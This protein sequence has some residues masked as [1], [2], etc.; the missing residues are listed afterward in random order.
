MPTF[1]RRPLRRLLNGAAPTDRRAASA[2]LLGS[3][4]EACEPR[5]LL[6]GAEPRLAV[7]P[8]DAINETSP[9]YANT[10]INDTIDAGGDVDL[11]RVSV[12]AGQQVEFDIDGFDTTGFDSEIRLFD[13]AG[14]QLAF[15][16]DNLAPGESGTPVRDAYIAQTFAEA[17]DYYLGVTSHLNNDYDILTGEDDNANANSGDYT[18]VITFE[19]GVGNDPND[20]ASEVRSQTRVNDF[21]FNGSIDYLGDVSLIPIGVTA[22]QTV[23]FDVNDAWDNDQLDTELRLFDAAGNVVAVQDDESSATR[24]PY[25][26]HTF[27]QTGL[28]Y[29]GIAGYRNDNYNPFTGRGDGTADPSIGTDT[30]RFTLAVDFRDGDGNADPD[31]QAIEAVVTSGSRSFRGTLEYNN[32]VD[33]YGFR[34]D[35]GRTVRFDTDLEG[36]FGQFLD[37]EIRLF[38][39]A[40]NELA[41]ND[42][43]NAPGE[44]N[45]LDSYLEYTFATA[46]TYYLAVADYRHDSYDVLTGVDT[47]ATGRSYGRYTLHAN[48]DGSTPIHSIQGTTATFST[49]AG[50]SGWRTLTGQIRF[51]DLTAFPEPDAALDGDFDGDGQLDVVLYRQSANRWSLMSNG[52]PLAQDLGPVP[53]TLRDV[54]AGDYNGDGFTDLAGISTAGDA[55]WVGLSVGSALIWSNWQSLPTTTGWQNV[56]VGDFNGDGRDDLAMQ[57]TSNG[58]W[59]FA[60][61]ATSGDR[62]ATASWGDSFGTTIQFAGIEVADVDGDGKDELIAL[63]PVTGFWLVGFVNE[64]ATFETWARWT[65]EARWTNVLVGDFD[66]DGRDDVAAQTATPTGDRDGVWYVAPSVLNENAAPEAVRGRFVGQKWSNRWNPAWGINTFRAADINGDGRTDLIGQADNGGWLVGVSTGESLAQGSGFDFASAAGLQP[67]PGT[68]FVL[69]GHQPTQPVDLANPTPPAPAPNAAAAFAMSED[70]APAAVVLDEAIGT[71]TLDELFAAV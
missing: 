9:I 59:Y 4:V 22:G 11:F 18:L 37:T 47:N 39:D 20:Q 7:D 35:A 45:T 62:F 56:R 53:T 38:D 64:E 29:I 34:V 12:H 44:P 8:N 70:D 60:T 57:T 67:L 19:G 43:G 49:L 13:A 51:P 40:G 21:T 71:A 25:L 69:L 10:Q 46:G 55:I 42:D 52:G 5:V 33:V 63:N 6:A 48:Y 14:T 58:K 36:D 50:P 15:S 3:V 1:S 54:R 23:I 16:D 30:G 31:D 2:L 32:D 65:T 27:A 24:N 26:Q 61:A 28:H 41:D 66:G 68:S 17:G